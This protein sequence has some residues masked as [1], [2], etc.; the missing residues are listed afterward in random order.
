MKI[1]SEYAYEKHYPEKHAT[2]EGVSKMKKV[3][4]I[5]VLGYPIQSK[6]QILQKRL[7]KALTY[8]NKHQIKTII[9]SGKGREELNEA[10]YMEKWL[11]DHQY[12]GTVIKEGHSLDTIENLLFCD[13]ICTNKKLQEK[14]I[15]TS[16]F[17]YLRSTILCH[18]LTSHAK[19]L[20]AK[21]AT[22][23]LV[24]SELFF[25]IPT[26]FGSRKKWITKR[27][28]AGYL[29]KLEKDTKSDSS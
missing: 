28:L 18:K 5:I 14:R 20:P 21:G 1:V 15:V 16:W 4:V 11:Q 26:I 9:V 22:V 23:A 6:Q 12:Q 27:G 29:E 8:A 7:M 3:D 24:F 25:I 19:V 10:D 13:V 2:M 17:H